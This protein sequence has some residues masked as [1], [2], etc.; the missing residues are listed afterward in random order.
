[1]AKDNISIEVLNSASIDDMIE[2]AVSSTGSSSRGGGGRGVS[3]CSITYHK[4]GKKVKLS[5]AVGSTPIIVTD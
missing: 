3:S 4:A 2:N 1:M 5:K